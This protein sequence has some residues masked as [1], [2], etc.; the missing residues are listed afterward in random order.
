[1]SRMSSLKELIPLRLRGAIG[2]L[3]DW[4]A[5]ALISLMYSLLYVSIF[6]GRD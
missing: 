6:Y 4:V 5:L 2:L 3:I 1:M